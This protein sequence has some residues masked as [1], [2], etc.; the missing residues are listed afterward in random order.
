[1]SGKPI[2]EAVRLLREYREAPKFS[3]DH[4]A[5]KR[6][7]ALEDEID[8]FLA[9]LT[10]AQQQGQA[11]AF[12]IERARTLADYV[13]GYA[14]AVEL[15]SLS[16][17]ACVALSDLHSML[18]AQ[19]MQQ[20]G[21]EVVAHGFYDPVT[22]AYSESQHTPRWL[23]AVVCTAPPSAPVGVEAVRGAWLAAITLANNI[24]V[25]ESDRENDRD[26]DT[27]W[28]D[29]TA[30]CAKRI[31]EYAHPTDAELLE[32]LDEA[33]ANA[34]KTALAQQPAAVDGV[35]GT[36]LRRDNRD[37]SEVLDHQIDLD[38]EFDERLNNMPA[39]TVVRLYAAPVRD[40]TLKQ[41]ADVAALAAQHQAPSP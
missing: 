4:D 8:A 39:G 16:S 11:V 10:A 23:P 35:V 29:G 21:G 27:A 12:D 9:A 28:I 36:V 24:C 26:G 19:P 37:G 38:P 32:M 40:L 15:K 20:G 6:T 34:A 18:H 5:I 33:G 3:N 22:G 25:Q 30:E 2:D 14:R 17:D 1:M 31:R 13:V 7:V 41:L